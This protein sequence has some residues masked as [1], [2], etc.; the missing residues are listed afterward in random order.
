MDVR[1]QRGLTVGLALEAH[2]PAALAE[3][4]EQLHAAEPLPGAQPPRRAGERLPDAVLDALEQQ[5]LGLSP[6][7]PPQPQPRRNDPRVVDDDQLSGELVRKVGEASVPH[8]A[9][10]AAVDEA[11]GRPRAAPSGRWAISSS[12][13]S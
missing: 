2:A 11:A 1:R 6:A 5:H 7:R 10:G 13:R 9:G 8:L 4:L 3:R 12:G